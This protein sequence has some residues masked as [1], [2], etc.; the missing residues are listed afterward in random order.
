MY[1]TQS[2]HRAVQQTPQAIATVF[3]DRQ[4]TWQQCA[5]RVAR[6]AAALREVGVSPGD[7]VAILARNS[8]YYHEYLYAVPWAGGVVNPVNV[9]WSVQ[10]IAYSLVDSGT[11]VLLVD[12]TFAHY[13]PDIRVLAELDAVIYLGECAPGGL[14]YEALIRRHDPVEDSFRGGSDLAGIFYTGGTTG[15]PKGVMLSHTNLLVSAMGFV[16]AQAPHPAGTTLHAAPLFHLAGLGMWLTRSTVGGTHAFVPA[17]EPTAVVAAIA[18]HSV[19]DTLLVP[20]MIQMLLDTGAAADGALDSLRNLVYG[21]SPISDTLIE[22]L[23]KELPSVRLTQ[24]YGMTELAPVAAVLDSAAHVDARLRR[25]AG[26]AATHTMVRI[27]NEHGEEAA[28]GA[29]GEIAV[30]GSNVM[31][32]YWNKPDQTAEALRGGWMH[33]GDAG[34]MD[35]HGYIFIVDRIKDMIVSG[36]ENVYSAEVENILAA[37][38]AIASCAVIGVPDP[39]W[40]ERVHAVVVVAAGHEVTAEELKA[41]CKSHIAGYKSPRSVE[42]VAGLPTSAA[43]KVL[44]TELRSKY[45]RD[46]D[47]SVN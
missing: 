37:H 42:F 9:R 11:R 31:L 7:R 34:W 24:A 47:R 26:R 4:R 13:V 8:D 29:L 43:G 20:S 10:E 18:E 19:A 15:T 36:S 35:E 28:R 23:L 41:H 14:E 2:L 46:R 6:F 45:W 40:G 39:E 16:A 22:R 33:T 27:V 12:S 38:P 44:K 3:G 32:G 5:E 21:A 17:F 30:R 1:F 25:S